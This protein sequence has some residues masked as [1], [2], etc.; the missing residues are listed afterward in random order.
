MVRDFNLAFLTKM[1]W[2]IFSNQDKLW[3]K[4]LR[5]KY[6][7][8]VDF[9][10]LQY[11]SNCSW[12]WK[13]VMKGKQVLLDGLKWNIGNGERVSFWNDWWA[14]DIPLHPIIV[15]FSLP[16][17]RVFWSVTSSL[18]KEIRTP[19]AFHACYLVMWWT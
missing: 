18:P 5:D 15:S 17:R 7:K 6:V 3:V 19:N 2:Q 13:S 12:G 11:D 9:L 4:V 8:D 16:L 14:G 10:N 1:A